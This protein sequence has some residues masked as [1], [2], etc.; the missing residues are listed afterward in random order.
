M[1]LLLLSVFL[2]FA[3]YSI[4]LTN[5]AGIPTIILFIIL[6]MFSNRIGFEFYNLDLVSTL[7]SYFLIVLSFYG[8]FAIKWDNVK[9][10][11]KESILLSTLGV[12]ITVVAIGGF[13]YL[14]F[15]FSILEGILLGAILGSTDAAGIFSILRSRKLSMKYDTNNII[16]I[17]SGANDTVAKSI[18]IA[19]IAA[20][21]TNTSM[22]PWITIR[23]IVVGLL[24]GLL[25]NYLYTFLIKRIDLSSSNLIFVFITTAMLISYSLADVVGGI[26]YLSVYIVG[27]GLGNIEFEGKRESAVFLEG[28]AGILQI[29][30]FFLL[31]GMSSPEN[32]IQQLPIAISLIVFITLVARP[33]AVYP[34]L[35]LFKKPTNQIRLI[36]FAGFRGST[37]IY[38]A[39]KT[40]NSNLSFQVVDIVFGVV[41]LSFIIQT[42]GLPRLI[43]ALK[44]NDTSTSIQ[45]SFNDYKHD[46]NIGF[47][48]ID[49]LPNSNWINKQI[50]DIDR[51]FNYI[52]AEIIRD[53]QVIIPK[54]STVLKENDSIV[55]AGKIYDNKKSMLSQVEIEVGHKWIDKKIK[56]INPERKKLVVM[57]IRNEEIL[58]PNGETTIRL[59]DILII[60]Q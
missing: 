7:A 3:F 23:L 47:I 40:L 48:N 13:L 45:K 52:I 8:G 37:A 60:S 20:M 50:K 28:I 35:K 55:I 56:N 22:I 24:V 32:I 30:L 21:A 33:L 49:L 18:T 1:N 12:L 43:N 4:N 25:V 44:M 27:L 39:L 17:E 2:L 42:L 16:Q 38:L 15:D 6:G 29:G 53:G 26:G 11:A 9:S 31:G 46:S 51:G 54:G 19:F 57:L 36:S 10:S 5:K 59:E 34:I 41:V 14:V 58:I